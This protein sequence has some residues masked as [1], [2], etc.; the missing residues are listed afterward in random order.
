MVP[1]LTKWLGRAPILLLVCSFWGILWYEQSRLAGCLHRRNFQCPWILKP[2]WSWCLGRIYSNSVP[3]TFRPFGSTDQL[4]AA[5]WCHG[6]WL[7]L[8]ILLTGLI[9]HLLESYLLFDQTFFAPFSP[10]RWHSS[11]VLFFEL[12]RWLRCSKFWFWSPMTSLGGG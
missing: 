4:F 5:G 10:S 1:S 9:T 8:S 6:W 7:S 11:L 3:A 2:V 12:I